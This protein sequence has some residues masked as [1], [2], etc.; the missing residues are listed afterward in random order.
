MIANIFSTRPLNISFRRSLVDANLQSWYNLVL[1]IADIQLTDQMDIFRWPLNSSGQFSVSSMYQ[2]MLD[3]DIIP[4]NIFLWKLKIPLKVKVFPWLL[5][6][7]VI[8]TKDNLV[9][10]NWHG[11]EQCCFCQ[12]YETIQH[13]LFDCKLVKFIWTITYFTFGLEFRV[14]INH[15]FGAWVLN[16]NSRTR[17]LVLVGIGA[18]LWSMWLSRNDIAFDKKLILSYM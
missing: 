5:F 13:L 4:H 12:N 18:M 14:S 8:L 11:N 2:A 15:L 9:K 10:R 6:R 17:K 16:M 3:S 1:R 7:K